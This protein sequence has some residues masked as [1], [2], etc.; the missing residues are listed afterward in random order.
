MRYSNRA[1]QTDPFIKKVIIKHR[2]SLLIKSVATPW[3]LIL[4]NYAFL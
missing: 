1:V 2:L 4:L 3:A